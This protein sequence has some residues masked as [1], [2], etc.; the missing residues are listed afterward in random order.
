VQNF[1]QCEDKNEDVNFSKLV[2]F[3]MQQAQIT[4]HPVFSAE[5][6]AKLESKPRVTAG[7]DQ[8]QSSRVKGQVK[9]K[10]ISLATK[11][12]ESKSAA[13]PVV[14]VSGAEIICPMCN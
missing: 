3:V 11:V 5:A 14:N 7:T 8:P 12:A 4:K 2:L 13:S 1:G 6:L 9:T 10:S